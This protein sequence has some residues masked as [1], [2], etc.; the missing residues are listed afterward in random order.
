MTK[1]HYT[2]WIYREGEVKDDLQAR[3]PACVC[4]LSVLFGGKRKRLS[5]NY[6]LLF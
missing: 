1:P 3:I 4:G 6:A 5:C 2:H